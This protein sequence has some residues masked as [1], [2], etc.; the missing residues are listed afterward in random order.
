MVSGRRFNGLQHIVT[1]AEKCIDRQDMF[2]LH[3]ALDEFNMSCCEGCGGCNGGEESEDGE[4]RECPSQMSMEQFLNEVGEVAFRYSCGHFD[5]DCSFDEGETNSELVELKRVLG[6]TTDE[7][8]T[9]LLELLGNS[10]GGNLSVYFSAN[11]NDMPPMNGSVVVKGTYINFSG[12]VNIGIV[13][14]FNGSGHHV[15]VPCELTFPFEWCR[16]WV[17]S[18]RPYSLT[19]DVFELSEDWC[20]STNFGFVYA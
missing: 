7:H 14:S 16:L 3:S 9:T 5:S 8:D 20:S 15:S 11:L 6:L 1:I 2:G 18:L 17:D 4:S 10:S 19:K 12:N 13:D